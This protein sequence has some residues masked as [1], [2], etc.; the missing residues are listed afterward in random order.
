[1]EL[2]FFFSPSSLGLIP[3]TSLGSS[4]FLLWFD[5]SEIFDVGGGE[6]LQLNSGTQDISGSG[7]LVGKQLQPTGSRSHFPPHYLNAQ[8]IHMSSRFL[9]YS[10]SQVDLEIQYFHINTPLCF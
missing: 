9:M 5:I 2:S 10:N 8:H 1:M 7:R 4:Q 6:R 3:A